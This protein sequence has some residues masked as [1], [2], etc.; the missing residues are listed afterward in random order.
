MRPQTIFEGALTVIAQG[1]NVAVT[2]LQIGAPVLENSPQF[3]SRRCSDQN[4]P[5]L[6]KLRAGP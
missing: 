6:K 2:A 4:P 1:G 3:P 5:I